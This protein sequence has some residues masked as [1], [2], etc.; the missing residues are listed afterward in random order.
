MGIGD[1]LTLEDLEHDPGPLLTRLRSE[2]PVCFIPALDMWLVTR[3]DDVAFVEAHPELFSGATE[4]SFLARTL[5]PN[6]LTMDAPEASRCRSAMLPPFQA[7]GVAG[8]FVAD[9]LADMSDDL[10]DGFASTGCADLMTS[11]ATPLSAATLATVLGIE[12]HGWAQVWKWCEGLCSDLANFTNDPELKAL[13]QRARESLAEA[14]GS[15]IDAAD[16]G[17]TESD[18]D[19]AI[20]AFCASR[21]EGGPLTR[22]EIINNVRLMISG[23]INEP[24]DGVGL[25]VATV[26][27]EPG[28]LAELRADPSL[29]RRCVEEVFRLHSP[30]GTITRQATQGVE[31]GGA[32]IKGG[33][34]VSGV[35]RSAN[36]DEQRWTDPDQF[37][38][39]RHDGGHAAF[40]LGA[41]RCLGE[42]MGRQVVRIGSMRLFERL[43][44]L[45]LADDEQVDLRGFEFRGPTSLRCRWDAP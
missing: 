34:L 27:R 2:E 36:L 26:L 11:Y 29:W 28:L 24:R 25:V 20:G 19:T 41:H 32:F 35:L 3:W 42:W 13:G 30:V 6:M 12:H 23:G 10:I 16:S 31:L 21:P 37:N 1:T 45:E 4:P 14:I 38:L 43:P 44:N 5:G 17:E 7:G 39:H 18:F 40:G 15:A 9:Q 22:D 8:K 33:D